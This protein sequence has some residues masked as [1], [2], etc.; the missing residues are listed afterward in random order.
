[1][2]VPALVAKG[3]IPPDTALVQS[4]PFFAVLGKLV[5]LQ[6]ITVLGADGCIQRRV[7]HVTGLVSHRPNLLFKLVFL[8]QIFISGTSVLRNFVGS[9]RYFLNMK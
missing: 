9:V 3:C 7:E 6:T 8:D 2:V 5:L 4:A 1:M